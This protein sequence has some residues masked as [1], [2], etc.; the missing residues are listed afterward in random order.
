[1]KQ[2]DLTIITTRFITYHIYKHLHDFVLINVLRW[3]YQTKYFFICLLFNSIKHFDL[4]V[5]TIASLLFIKFR[6]IFITKHS[7]E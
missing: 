5:L 4:N 6:I 1:M 7:S 3:T 2:R